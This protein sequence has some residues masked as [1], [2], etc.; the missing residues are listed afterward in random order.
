VYVITRKDAA[1]GIAADKAIFVIEIPDSESAPHQATDRKY[2]ARIAGK[3]KP[4]GHRMVLDI[5]GRIKHP[6]IE[7]GL[8]ARW[9]GRLGKLHVV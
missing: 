3:S 6:K 8:E 1:S 9:R 4:I 2:Y 5:L 7:V